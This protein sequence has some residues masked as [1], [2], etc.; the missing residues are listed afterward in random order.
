MCC[1]RLDKYVLILFS[2]LK[3]LINESEIPIFNLHFYN[4]DNSVTN[5]ENILKFSGVVLQV[6]FERIESHI[7]DLDTSLKYT[8][9]Y[10][11]FYIKSKPK[12]YPN[13]ES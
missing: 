4:K 13:V 3:L 7:F 10:W 12:P 11:L 5:E 2:L 8:E 1:S 6:F 9:G